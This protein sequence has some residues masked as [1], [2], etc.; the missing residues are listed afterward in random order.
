[1]PLALILVAGI[2]GGIIMGDLAHIAVNH[3]QDSK[4][5]STVQK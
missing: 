5:V 4:T 3:H 2:I 1:M